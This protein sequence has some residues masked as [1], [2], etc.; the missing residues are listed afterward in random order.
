MIQ[1][2]GHGRLVELSRIDGD[3]HPVSS[4]LQVAPVFS[5]V[6][7]G[8]HIDFRTDWTA[9]PLVTAGTTLR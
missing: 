8:T 1:K 5:F 3:F 2:T 4:V 7:A 9:L 6:A